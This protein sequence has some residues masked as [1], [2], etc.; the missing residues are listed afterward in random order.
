MIKMA[1]LLHPCVYNMEVK[2]SEIK[3]RLDEHWTEWRVRFEQTLLQ[4]PAPVPEKYVVVGSVSTRTCVAGSDVDILMVFRQSVAAHKQSVQRC[5]RRV[6]TDAI[7]SSAGARISLEALPVD[8]LLTTRGILTA[9]ERM[10]YEKL[11]EERGGDRL[12]RSENPF[13]ILLW[14]SD[15]VRI[16]DNRYAINLFNQHAK[17]LPHLRRATRCLKVLFNRTWNAQVGHRFRLASHAMEVL[18]VEFAVRHKGDVTW[19]VRPLLYTIRGCLKLLESRVLSDD[20]WCPLTSFDCDM[21]AGRAFPEVRSA[22][23]GL[24]SALH[25]T[26]DARLMETI[27]RSERQ[28]DSSPIVLWTPQR[29][30]MS[31]TAL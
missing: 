16:S 3:R 22:M 18:C 4:T 15:A 21:L 8:L 2:T 20:P 14:D 5:I 7:F 26:P 12:H 24:L 6:S 23:I 25:M 1:G 10:C 29:A 9:E 17:R 11:D 19:P 28:Q 27:L 30:N 31:K 13:H